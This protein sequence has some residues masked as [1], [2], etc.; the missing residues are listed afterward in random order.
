MGHTCHTGRPRTISLNKMGE[1]NNFTDFSN[2]TQIKT[3]LQKEQVGTKKQQS[4]LR[5]TAKIE[6]ERERER[7]FKEKV[8]TE[9]SSFEFVSSAVWF[10]G[11]RHVK[12]AGAWGF[13]LKKAREF[14]NFSPPRNGGEQFPGDPAPK[15][16]H[17]QKCSQLPRAACCEPVLPCRTGSVKSGCL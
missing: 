12:E 2:K 3:H 5:T 7:I 16:A 14:G 11:S 10:W 15:G 13:R 8:R 4:Y 1:S 17:F 6:R 9:G